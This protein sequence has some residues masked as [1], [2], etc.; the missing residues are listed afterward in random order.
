MSINGFFYKYLFCPPTDSVSTSP[1]SEEDDSS[2]KEV[3]LNKEYEV[4]EEINLK[5]KSGMHY[6]GATNIQSSYMLIKNLFYV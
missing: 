1:V 2:D 5:R 3:S 4:E 6:S